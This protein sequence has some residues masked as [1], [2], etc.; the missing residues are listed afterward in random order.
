M[1]ILAQLNVIISFLALSKKL[2]LGDKLLQRIFDE[3][4]N[5]LSLLDQLSLALFSDGI[6]ESDLVIALELGIRNAIKHCNDAKNI[7]IRSISVHPSREEINAIL[8][9]VR[10]SLEEVTKWTI[11]AYSQ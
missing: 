2:P 5:A 8:V 9:Q 6:E 7:Y 10:I 4:K 11:E 1:G 3:M